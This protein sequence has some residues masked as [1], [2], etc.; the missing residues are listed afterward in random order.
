MQVSTKFTIAIHILAATQYFQSRQKVTG[1]L[2]AASIGSNPALVRK[3]LSNLKKAGLIQTKP[4][5]GGITIARDLDDVTFLDVYNAVETNKETL[6]HFHE[7]LHPDC[8]VASNIHAALDDRLDRIQREF[9]ESL[10]QVTVGEVTRE[11]TGKIQ[12]A[13]KTGGD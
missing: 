1:D 9:E 8:P 4:G 11:L 12:T 5:I 7:G 6:F 3:L 10:R 2:L 13:Q